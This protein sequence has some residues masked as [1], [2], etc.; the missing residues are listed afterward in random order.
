MFEILKGTILH[1]FRKD[2][3]FANKEIFHFMHLAFQTSQNKLR[4]RSFV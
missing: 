3:D 2:D 4:D 1:V